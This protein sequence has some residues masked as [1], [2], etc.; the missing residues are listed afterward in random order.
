MNNGRDPVFKNT[1]G[2]SLDKSLDSLGFKNPN[3]DISSLDSDLKFLKYRYNKLTELNK[4]IDEL[5]S[6][7]EYNVLVN[8]EFI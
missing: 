5:K 7:G 6:V 4:Y 3:K 2:K 1:I 8:Y